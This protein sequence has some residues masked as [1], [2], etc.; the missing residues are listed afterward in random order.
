MKLRPPDLEENELEN[1]KL[2][3][4]TEDLLSIHSN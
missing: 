3:K 4:L 2:G 1:L